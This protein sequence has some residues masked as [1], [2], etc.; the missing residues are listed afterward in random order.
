[1]AALDLASQRAY[2]DR[3]N[4]VP[5]IPV[6]IAFAGNDP[7]I[8]VEI[9]RELGDAFDSNRELVC[10]ADDAY[11]TSRQVDELMHIDGHRH[12]SV[13]FERDGHFLQKFRADFLADVIRTMTRLRR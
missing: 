13:L 5:T 10:I 3:L 12:L 11:E 8:E 2:V 1:M 7:L 9:S 4:A 6:L